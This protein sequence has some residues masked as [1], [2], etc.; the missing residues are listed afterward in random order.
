MA[1]ERHV[2]LTVNGQRR[3]SF[4]VHS[5]GGG[6]SLHIGGANPWAVGPPQG[7]LSSTYMCRDLA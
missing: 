5:G 2:L 3:S 6:S 4:R 7:A 1:D